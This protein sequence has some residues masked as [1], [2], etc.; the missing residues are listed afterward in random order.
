MTSENI[1]QKDWYE[2]L[3]A[4]PSHSMQELRQN[5]QKLV[6]LYHPD[7]QNAD[8]PVGELEERIQRFIEVD[9]AWKILGNEETKKEYDLQRR[10]V[11]MSQTWPV[12][13]QVPLE[14]MHWVAADQ[15]YKYDCRC[16]G[17]YV[18]SKEEVEENVFLLCCNSC[19]LSIEI[20]NGS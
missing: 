2:I 14:D 16:G 18:L 9:Q 15:C 4:S 17:E 19:S 5:Y 8:V 10:E 11:T 3:G 12:D 6:L 20:L 1:L 7:K 13:A